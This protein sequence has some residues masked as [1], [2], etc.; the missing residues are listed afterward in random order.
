VSKLADKLGKNP[1]TKKGVKNMLKGSKKWVA[2]AG[3]SVAAAIVL[4]VGGIV[5]GV[6]TGVIPAL[7]QEVVDDGPPFGMWHGHGM[8]RGGFGWPGGAWTMFDTAAEALGLTPEELFAELHA[9]KSLAEVA[10]EQGIDLDAVYD[11]M[12]TARGEAMRE[13]IEQAVEDGSLTQ[14]QADWLLEGLDQGF[15]PGRRGFGFGHGHGFGGRI[16]CPH[17]G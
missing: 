4:L 14:E 1:Y 3:M 13:H 5:G 11:A 9:D 8:G 17:E 12:R 6:V 2:V 7:A 15:F 16:G 10:E